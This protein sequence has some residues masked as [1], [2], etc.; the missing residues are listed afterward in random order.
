[1]GILPSGRTIA[2]MY[3]PKSSARV[4]IL[5]AMAAISAIAILGTAG[6]SSAQS[7]SG[8]C[9]TTVGSN[10]SGQVNITCSGLP[11]ELAEHI[12]K[13]VNLLL[14]QQ[15]QNSDIIAKLD[16]LYRS[17]SKMNARSEAEHITLLE[18]ISERRRQCEEMQPDLALRVERREQ[19]SN[20]IYTLGFDND[21]LAKIR[22]A[23]GANNVSVFQE[24]QTAQTNLE[25]SLPRYS[26]SAASLSGVEDVLKTDAR[27]PPL[28]PA[29]LAQQHK[30]AADLQKDIVGI[31]KEF[32]QSFSRFCNSLKDVEASCTSDL[33]VK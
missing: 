18:R 9:N 10:N 24:M 32:N 7:I 13:L 15:G 19:P 5:R 23:L 27:L 21:S 16:D 8:T 11:P 20:E 22:V 30:W 3:M 26:N 17:L 25:D 4:D 14:S 28:P 2:A 29:V 31:G 1:V 33:C 12:T 6:S